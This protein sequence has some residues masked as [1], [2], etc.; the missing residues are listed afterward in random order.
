MSGAANGTAQTTKAVVSDANDSSKPLAPPKAVAQLEEDDE[1]E[2]FP[3]E[4]KP[5][6]LTTNTHT[7][8]YIASCT[9]KTNKHTASQPARN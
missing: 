4:G 2:D 9:Q 8:T 3:V 1:F 7:H 5:A 6:P